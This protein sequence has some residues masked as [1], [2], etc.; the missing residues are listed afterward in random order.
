MNEVVE[1]EEVG[2]VSGAVS[3]AVSGWVVSRE[4]ELSWHC[5][6]LIENSQLEEEEYQT[7]AVLQGIAV[8]TE[9]E[10]GTLVDK[11]SAVTLIAKKWIMPSKVPKT[12]LLVKGLGELKSIGQ[13]NSLPTKG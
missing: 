1:L 6:C 10:A 4:L 11:Y 5:C 7:K 3:E 9:P 12:R 13:R 8:Q 2:S